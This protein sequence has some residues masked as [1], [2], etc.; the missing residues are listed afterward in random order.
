VA[1]DPRR[2]A[3]V[4]RE[5]AH[6]YQD[7]DLLVIGV[8]APAGAT[9]SRR[10]RRPADY[11]QPRPPHR[12]QVLKGAFVFT[13]GAIRAPLLSPGCPS[14]TTHWPAPACRCPADPPP[15]HPPQTWC[16]TSTRSRTTCWWSLSR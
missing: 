4:R 2:A 1:A 6:A 8:S 5:L 12:L 16:A 10:A 13:A 11:D 15:H 7:K 3:P 14:T 9:A